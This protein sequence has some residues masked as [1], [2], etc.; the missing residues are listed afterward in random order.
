MIFSGS[1]RKA[2]T[3]AGGAAISVSR[4]TTSASFI[5]SLLDLLITTREDAAAGHLHGRLSR[6]RTNKCVQRS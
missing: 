3:V 1:V 2:N 6:Q 5:K 4:R